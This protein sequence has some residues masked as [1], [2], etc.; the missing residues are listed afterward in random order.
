[1]ANRLLRSICEPQR[2]GF[3]LGNV[4]GQA[5]STQDLDK[6]AN[7]NPRMRDDAEYVRLWAANGGDTMLQYDDIRAW[8]KFG[9]W[10]ALEYVTQVW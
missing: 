10:G 5:A 8:S 1:M 4:A 7:R 6:Q 2:K 9:T 3:P